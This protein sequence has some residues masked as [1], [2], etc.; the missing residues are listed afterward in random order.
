MKKVALSI[1]IAIVSLSSCTNEEFTDSDLTTE[2][3]TE[4]KPVVFG[5]YIEKT[6]SSRA[7]N[8]STTTLSAKNGFGVCPT[9]YDP[10]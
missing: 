2:S 5:T 1:M 10:R 3:T 4:Q 6:A 7:A 8:T 9:R